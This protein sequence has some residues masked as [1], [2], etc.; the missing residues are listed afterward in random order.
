MR[1]S[2][3]LSPPPSL[4]VTS[5]L[6]HSNASWPNSALGRGGVIFILTTGCPLT[7]LHLVT[8]QEDLVTPEHGATGLIHAC[9]L[10]VGGVG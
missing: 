8:E 2:K 6:C 10:Q 3:L 4:G 1:R 5:Q 9:D 7:L